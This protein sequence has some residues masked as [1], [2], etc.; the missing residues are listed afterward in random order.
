MVIVNVR[1]L[2]CTGDCAVTKTNEAFAPHVK[3][4]DGALG[5]V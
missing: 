5:T 3:I 1:Q 4:V 2:M